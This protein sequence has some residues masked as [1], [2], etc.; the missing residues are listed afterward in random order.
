MLGE[1]C[2]QHSRRQI[3]H[4]GISVQFTRILILEFWW[5]SLQNVCRERNRDE[6]GDI[7][8]MIESA[9]RDGHGQEHGTSF[10]MDSPSP[11]IWDALSERRKL[12]ASKWSARR[13]EAAE[14][15]MEQCWVQADE[16]S[17]QRDIIQVINT[18][19]CCSVVK[20][21]VQWGAIYIL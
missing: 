13:W 6:K 8:G 20:F 2:L 7:T 17:V 9:S 19:S 15:T 11:V 16:V 4:S 1:G 3:Y 18:T 14:R 12:F 10:C 5:F 21:E